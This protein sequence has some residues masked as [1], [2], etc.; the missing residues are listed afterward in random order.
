ME[1]LRVA[2]EMAIVATSYLDTVESSIEPAELAQWKQAEMQWKEK[3]VDIAQHKD[4]DNPYEPPRDACKLHSSS[5][6]VHPL[7]SA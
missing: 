6:T 2:D 1:K 5:A 7:T 3:V 4:L